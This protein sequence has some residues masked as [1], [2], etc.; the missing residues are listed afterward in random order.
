M[1]T[2]IIVSKKDIAGMNIKKILI[3]QHNF[4]QTKELFH[5]ERVYKRESTKLYTTDNETIFSERID[6]EIPEDIIIFA[7]RHKAESG[8]KSFSVH[9]TGNWSK[10]EAGGKDKTLCVA[11]PSLMKEALKK[12]SELYKGAEFE[13]IQESTHHG[14]FMEKPCMFI[15]VGSSAEEWARTDTCSVIA[16]T[17]TCL[18]ESKIK[19]Y[20]EVVVLGGGHYNQVATKLMLNSN[21]AVGHICP[22]H[23]LSELTP[24]LLRQAIEKNGSNFEFVVLDWKGLGTEK[25]RIKQMLDELG[26]RYERYQACNK[27]PQAKATPLF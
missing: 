26:I 9:V 8:K 23:F 27:F 13:I 22:K 6:E 24:A 3:T 16:N 21:Y 20:P 10:A 14:P 17:I 2:A 25:Q 15:E 18:I 19:K 12:I 7:T 5:N 11:L 1:K 4:E